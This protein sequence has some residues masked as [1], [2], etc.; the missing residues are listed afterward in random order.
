MLFHDDFF[1]DPSQHF[2]LSVNGP[3]MTNMKTDPNGCDEVFTPKNP[4]E[5]TFVDS[6]QTNKNL[7]KNKTEPC[8]EVPQLAADSEHLSDNESEASLASA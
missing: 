7:C 2:C 1:S 4:I 8:R 3:G 6:R 5:S